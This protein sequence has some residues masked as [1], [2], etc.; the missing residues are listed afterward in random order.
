[1]DSNNPAETEEVLTAGL[2]IAREVLAE[3][4]AAV[5]SSKQ[6]TAVLKV[7]EL[8]SL[9]VSGL[10]QPIYACKTC[11]SENGGSPVGV[12]C[13]VEHNGCPGAKMSLLQAVITS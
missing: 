7:A 5:A 10:K 12:W 6:C 11:A 2:F 13:V 8:E 1:M 9:G 4:E 3:V